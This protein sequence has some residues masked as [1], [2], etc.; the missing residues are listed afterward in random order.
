MTDPATNLQRHRRLRRFQA[1]METPMIVLAFVWLAL[2]VAEAVWGANRWLGIAGAVIWAIFLVEFVIG[3]VLAPDKS[4]YF[5][6][7]WLAALALAAPA[8]RMLRVFRLARL[9]VFARGSR[10][11]RIASSVNRS[12]RALGRS[13]G[14]RGAGYVLVL[15][16]VVLFVGA[17]GMYA[18]ENE[19][20]ALNFDGYA[21]ALWWTAMLMTTIGSAYW[22]QTTAGRVLCFALSMFSIGVFGYITAALA[23]FFV[24][25]DAGTGAAEPGSVDLRELKAEMTALRKALEARGDVPAG[26]AGQPR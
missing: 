23:S 5:G 2:F 10:M 16:V 3:L 12:M 9:A 22:P 15:S 11:L 25:R 20:G 4:H 18:F 1:R 17:A 24:G 21:D 26:N 7:N 14:R 19:G 6:R 13:I 8:L